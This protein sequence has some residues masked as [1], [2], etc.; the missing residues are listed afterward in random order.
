MS[1]LKLCQHWS[2]IN[3]E[4]TENNEMAFKGT[5][6]TS[7]YWY[8]TKHLNA[9]SNSLASCVMN[10]CRL[11]AL[12]ERWSHLNTTRALVDVWPASEIATGKATR[13]T[14]SQYFRDCYIVNVYHYCLIVKSVLL[15]YA[16]KVAILKSSHNWCSYS[17]FFTAL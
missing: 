11:S 17:K 7:K 8:H 9:W 3:T 13:A 16:W 6:F 1:I 15:L 2:Y 5:I 14:F 10:Y 12:Q 4:A